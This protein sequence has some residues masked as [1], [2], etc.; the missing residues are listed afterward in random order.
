[1][2]IQ[3]PDDSEDKFFFLQKDPQINA[4][5]HAP[6]FI[7][8]KIPDFGTNKSKT[9]GNIDSLELSKLAIQSEE[10]NQQDLEDQDKKREDLYNF[11]LNPT[12]KVINCPYPKCKEPLEKVLID[13]INASSLSCTDDTLEIVRTDNNNID[14]TAERFG[15]SDIEKIFN[16]E[17]LNWEKAGDLFTPGSKDTRDEYKYRSDGNEVAANAL[18]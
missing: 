5:I 16:Q 17:D 8:L 2:P 7:A 14:V 12:S 6:I 10:Q 13:L 1:V 4:K 15:D 9:A 18:K 11:A 3:D